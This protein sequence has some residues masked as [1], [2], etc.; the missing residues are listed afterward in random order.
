MI[1]HVSTTV[2]THQEVTSVLVAAVLHW[3]ATT[4]TVQVTVETSSQC[5]VCGL[6][7]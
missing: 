1:N 5:N 3:T 4:D 6:S 7:V 2:A